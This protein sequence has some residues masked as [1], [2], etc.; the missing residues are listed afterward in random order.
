M[1]RI[2]GIDLGTCYS[3]ITI[4]EE[5]RAEGFFVLPECP[6]YSVILDKLGRRIVP[7]V[8]AEDDAGDILVGHPA[9]ARAGLSPEPIMFAKRWMGEDKTF[10]LGRRGVF[11]PVDASRHILEHLVGLA[12]TRLGEAVDEAVITVPAYFSLK[13]KQ[14][15][16]EAAKLAG[17]RVA[18]LAQEPVAAALMYCVNDARDPLRVMTYDLGGGT[19]DVAILEK[20]DGVIS[21]DS[22]LAFDGDRFLGGYEFDKSLALWIAD[23]L[24]SQGYDLSLNLDDPADKLLFA[25]LMVY[26]ER[27]KV[28]LSKELTAQIQ[29]PATG[30]KD[31]RGNPVAIQLEIARGQFEDMI[32]T[33]VDYT[34]RITHRAREEKAKEK[35]GEQVPRESIDEIL[36]V[37]GSS[38]IPLIAQRLEEE[39]GRKPRLVE[40]DLCV[41]LGAAIIA[42]AESRSIG[43]LRLDRIPERTDLPTV[44]VTGS[45]VAGAQLASVVGCRVSLRAQDG[46]YDQNRVVRADGAFVFD[47]VPLAPL[48][49]TE[50]VLTVA[51]PT[52]AKLAEHRFSVTH[53]EGE[54]IIH[55]P[56]VLSKPILIQWAEGTE[57]IAPEG[58]EL[59]FETVVQAQTRDKSGRI[60][61]PILEASNP[62]GEIVMSDIPRTLDIGSTVEVTLTI[63][64]NYSIT[65]RAKVPALQKEAKVE[66]PLPLRP[67]KTMDELRGDFE[68]LAARA[69]DALRNLPPSSVFREAKKIERLK[70]LLPACREMLRSRVPDPAAIQDRM[71]EIEGLVRALRPTW[72]PDPPRPAFEQKVHDV[73]ELHGQLLSGDPALAQ[74][75]YLERLK[76]IQD[77]ADQAYKTQNGAAWKEA[78]NKLLRL[79]D[80][81]AS[82]EKRPQPPPPAPQV[83]L[84]ELGRELDQLKDWADKQGRYLEF[85]ADF[86]NLADSLKAIKPGAPDAMNQIYDWYFVKFADLKQRLKA[87]VE[88]KLEGLLSRQGRGARV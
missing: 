14:M 7:S 6:G 75:G 63:K 77:E 36:M 1:G 26:A 25:K 32:K 24:N 4:P 60:R 81:L 73:N 71:D 20:R 34:L 41:A 3:A 84:I 8:V 59:D 22:I 56:Q 68:L 53:G 65:G 74:Y 27:A 45:V 37:G 23:Q 13:A 38:R 47:Q 70:Y 80:D 83:L 17:L 44:A 86:Q 21:A 12:K 10:A 61:I 40:P 51:S 78:W 87:P 82:H 2:V 35:L 57:L 43:C 64:K 16:E 76:A 46:S 69:D 62:L 39:Y 54:K 18:K 28:E 29:E 48:T 66:I 72:R 42:G 33:Q 88:S 67:Q 79:A 55:P 85:K 9:K 31:H 19:F 11:R 50:F 52:G 5:R 30:L 15:T 49:T 58:T